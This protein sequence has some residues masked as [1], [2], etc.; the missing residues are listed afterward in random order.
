MKGIRVLAWLIA[1]PIAFAGVVLFITGLVVPASERTEDGDPAGPFFM[2]F[3]AG[4]LVA[5]AAVFVGVRWLLRG[6][7][8]R[9]AREQEQREFL[10]RRGVRVEA[11]VVSCETD[12]YLDPA[13]NHWTT[14][15]LEYVISGAPPQGMKRHLPLPAPLLERARAGG[16]IPIL[17]HPSLP[18][19]FEL[20]PEALSL[21]PEASAAMRMH[22]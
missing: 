8:E 4:S 21:G 22:H 13:N 3:G 11:R 9:H 12:G 14:L 17:V 2:A 18:G 7:E 16:T 10:L 5:S 20:A 1:V 19:V 15:V 6:A